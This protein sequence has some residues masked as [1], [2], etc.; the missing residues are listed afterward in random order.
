MNKFVFPAK[1]IDE[2]SFASSRTV[3]HCAKRKTSGIRLKDVRLG[4]IQSFVSV[5]LFLSPHDLPLGFW[6]G[7]SD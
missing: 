5:D 6:T 7:R 1:S 2:V 3:G 4:R